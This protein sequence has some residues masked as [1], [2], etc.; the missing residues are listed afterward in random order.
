MSGTYK[1]EYNGFP[2]YVKARNKES[3]EAQIKWLEGEDL[4]LANR[5]CLCEDCRNKLR[6]ES[7]ISFIAQDIPVEFYCP[8]HRTADYLEENPINY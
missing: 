7:S 5:Q 4:A 6:K 2:A 8:I 3:A 1:V